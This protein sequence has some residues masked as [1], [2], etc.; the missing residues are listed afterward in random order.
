[1]A[2]KYLESKIPKNIDEA[3]ELNRGQASSQP[4]K[5]NKI[6]LSKYNVVVTKGQMIVEK[7]NYDSDETESLP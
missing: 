3:A 7:C 4:H 2:I 5:K 6:Y 1:M